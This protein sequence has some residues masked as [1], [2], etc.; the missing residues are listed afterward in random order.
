LALGI[1]ADAEEECAGGE[2]PDFAGFH[3]SQLQARDFLVIDVINIFDDGV[4][5]ELNFLV[6]LRAL[7][8]DFGSAETFAA[9]NE[10]DLGGEAGEEDRFLHGGVAAADH[11]DFFAGKEKAVAGGAGRNAVADQLLLVRQ[12]QP[13]GG[14]AAGDDQGLA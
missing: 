8:H 14:G 11:D 1:V 10:R 6:V 13:A 3:V 7:Q 9:M 5:E 4:G 12:A 2:I